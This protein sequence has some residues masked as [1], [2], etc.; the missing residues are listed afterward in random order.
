MNR[1][2][3][4]ESILLVFIFCRLNRPYSC[5]NK[6]GKGFQEICRV[7]L[8]GVGDR[9]RTS[10][11]LPKTLVRVSQI[12][13]S[14]DSGFCKEKLFRRGLFK[15]WGLFLIFKTLQTYEMKLWRRLRPLNMDDMSETRL[16]RMGKFVQT[17]SE[18]NMA[19]V[20][21]FKVTK[22][23]FTNRRHLNVKTLHKNWKFCWKFGNTS[24]F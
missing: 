18:Q 23:Y 9:N 15:T 5:L 17:T 22:R 4:T 20:F 10:S 21:F 7:I 11:F 14:I 3:L 12:G 13:R 2:R 24:F 1:L 16:E 6:N 19:W 8:F